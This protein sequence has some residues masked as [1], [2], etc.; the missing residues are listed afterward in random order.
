MVKLYHFRTKYSR[1]NNVILRN[2]SVINSFSCVEDIILYFRMMFQQFSIK[3]LPTEMLENIFSMLHLLDL[4]QAVLVCTK[5]R[6]VGENS[7]LWKRHGFSHLEIFV[8]SD[9]S[10]LEMRRMQ[11]LE[12]LTLDTDLKL[13]ISEL[14]QLIRSVEKLERLKY[15]DIPRNNLSSFKP[16]RLAKMV[17]KLLA[18]D[19]S[20]CSLTNKQVHAIIEV[21]SKNSKMENLHISDNDLSTVESL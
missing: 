13:G 16:V 11:H 2:K 5:W 7:R 8:E 9:L 18:L 14:E 1:L 3:M 4:Q 6:Q 15:L 21:L 12:E 17:S 10:F 20:N 19:I